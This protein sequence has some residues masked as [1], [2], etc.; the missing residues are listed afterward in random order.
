MPDVLSKEPG[1]SPDSVAL[2]EKRG[3]IVKRVNAQ[4]EAVPA[5]RFV[6]VP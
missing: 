3:C 2:L 4:G 5:V 1:F 6:N